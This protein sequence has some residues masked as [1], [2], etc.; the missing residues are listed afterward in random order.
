[1]VAGYA[2]DVETEAF[3]ACVRREADGVRERRAPLLRAIPL[4]EMDDPKP[5]IELEAFHHP[6]SGVGFAKMFAAAGALANKAD[7]VDWIENR[8][9]AV[10]KPSTL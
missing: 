9:N 4:M 10:M 6:D 2:F 3:Q 1:M 7:G 5:R 8:G